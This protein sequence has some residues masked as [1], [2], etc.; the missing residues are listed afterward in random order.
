MSCWRFTLSQ[1]CRGFL[2]SSLAASQ[3]AH[4][5]V[6][7]LHLLFPTDGNQADIRVCPKL[8]LH[9]LGWVQPPVLGVP[10]PVGEM[11]SVWVKQSREALVSCLH[12][13]R[14]LLQALSILDKDKWTAFPS[15]L[16]IKKP[17]SLKAQ[18]TNTSR[19]VSTLPVFLKPCTTVFWNLSTH[20]RLSTKSLTRIR[21]TGWFFFFQTNE[22]NLITIMWGKMD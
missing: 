9:P 7:L 20:K 4:S 13:R 12:R 6:I 2:S 19:K 10:R 17:F 16:Y 18:C 15:M 1:S 11:K 22:Q 5:E 8:P 14:L 3:N 21:N